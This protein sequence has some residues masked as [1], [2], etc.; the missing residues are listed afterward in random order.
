M[1][2]YAVYRG[3]AG[4]FL[5]PPGRSTVRIRDAEILFYC[6]AQEVHV[7][8][9]PR[10]SAKT[11]FQAGQHFQLPG[12]S[13]DAVID[14]WLSAYA[15]GYDRFRKVVLAGGTGVIGRAIECEFVLQDP[16]LAPRQIFLQGAHVR[17]AGELPL[18]SVNGKTVS[19]TD[20]QPGDILRFL[21][22]QMIYHPL[23]WM[24]SCVGNFFCALPAWQRPVRGGPL[25][26]RSQTEQEPL[27]LCP[28]ALPQFAEELAEPEPLPGRTRSPLIFTMGPAITMSAASLLSGSIAFHNGLLSGRRPLDLLPSVLLPLVMLASA[29]I[30]NPAQRFYEKRREKRAREERLRHYQE[31]L[32]ALRKR[33]ADY[34]ETVRKQAWQEYPEAGKIEEEALAGRL[35]R[36]NP[37]QPQWLCWRLGSC[38][39]EIPVQLTHS[40]RFTAGDPVKELVRR[41]QEESRQ[42][43]CLPLLVHLQQYQNITVLCADPLAAMEEM[44]HQICALYHPDHL[45]IGIFCTAEQYDRAPWLKRIPHTRIGSRAALR[46]VTWQP[47]ELES[48]EQAL[49]QEPPGAF[50]LLNTG[51]AYQL[52]FHLERGTAVYFTDQGR[53]PAATQLLVDQIHQ[54]LRLPQESLSYQTDPRPGCDSLT[55]FTRLLDHAG[56]RQDVSTSGVG[57]LNLFQVSRA[58]ELPISRYWVEHRVREGLAVPI[59]LDEKGECFT[60]D[61]SEQGMGPHGLI[62]GMT[63]SG[64][65]EFIITLILS[66]AVWFSPRELQFSL[67]DFKGGGAASA[68][69]N[70][71]FHLPHLAGDLSD[72]EIEDMERSLAAYRNECQRRE[73]LFRQMQSRLKTSISH[74]HAYQEA[75]RQDLHLPY[76]A[77]LIVIVDE[78]AE[79]KQNRPEFMKELVSIAR[80]G[81]SLGIHLI[82]VTQKPSGII[83]E[84]IWSNSRFKIAL[85]VQDRQDS[86]EVLHQPDASYIRQPG[87][88]YL[89][90]DG[91]LRHGYA[92]YTQAPVRQEAGMEHLD[93]R[94]R[95]LPLHA[96]PA[97][98]QQTQLAAVLAQIQ[99]QPEAR[100]VRQLWLPVLQAGEYPEKADAFVIGQLDDYRNGTQPP[101]CLDPQTVTVNALF[102][103]DRQIRFQFLQTV[104]YS[105]LRSTGA[106]DEIYVIDDLG[107]DFSFCSSFHQ[108]IALLDSEETEKIRNL[109]RH[110]KTPTEGHR[111]V[112]VTQYSSL[113][114]DQ[115]PR[116]KAFH[117][118]MEHAQRYHLWFLICGTSSETISYRDLALAGLKIC[119]KN[120]NLQE[121]T[122]LLETAIRRPLQKPWSCYVR[123][124]EVL[125]AMF[126]EVRPARFVTLLQEN[127]ENY[128]G[129]AKIYQIPCIPEP[130]HAPACSPGRII[131][132]MDVET[133]EWV[134]WSAAQPLLVLSLYEEEQV[135]FRQ[136]CSEEALFRYLTLEDYLAAKE[137]FRN[138]PVLFVGSGFQEQF[139]FRL[140]RR[141]ALQEHEGVLFARQKRRVIHLVE[142]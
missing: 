90:V 18:L 25:P 111:F 49:N 82:L 141:K 128:A 10:T 121:L 99:K 57:F 21:N 29:L 17:C 59:G 117:E 140:P 7:L 39:Q 16:A 6:R 24:I 78:F 115:E 65:S 44:L 54:V 104:L 137:Q 127:R 9:R 139:E 14:C 133:Y 85:K 43:Y 28:S 116:R 109:L 13:A 20:L 123:R 122:T 126:Y 37:V 42:L 79:L 66:L 110:L 81:R 48:F 30:W 38:R 92:A 3:Q 68:F 125:E 106:Q 64:K 5:L 11:V 89:S 36:K 34:Q 102:G 47:A 35:Y 131:L 134:C 62:A 71:Y 97:R 114:A 80:V 27:F 32:Q 55:Y 76:L 31:Y 94:L 130:L 73:R 84:Q 93:H 132:G 96:E 60:L 113:T 135:F 142:P 77:E 72:L 70:A 120:E 1:M 75:W 129:M 26:A 74:L 100:P 58:E 61:L 12:S 56:I 91:S 86:L 108:F 45:K 103:M 119:L 95:T 112:I 88:F 138:L 69:H 124:S 63:G 23:F 4:C 22:V 101:L 87:E 67:I 41:L 52:P 2:L 51:N 15:E 40:F 118:L 105:L 83:D 33:I 8:S 136:A 107:Y 98:E 50:L 19:E 53:V 46:F